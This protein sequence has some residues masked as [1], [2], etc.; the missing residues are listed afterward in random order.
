MQKDLQ[1]EIILINEKNEKD[2]LLLK[3]RL[4]KEEKEVCV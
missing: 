1:N 2:I 3:D 4:E